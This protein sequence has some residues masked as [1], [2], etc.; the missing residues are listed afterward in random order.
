MQKKVA[1]LGSTGSIG[2]Q[3]LQVLEHLSDEFVPVSLAAF[4]NIDLLEEQIQKFSVRK[5]AVFDEKKALELAKRL[6][7]VEVLTGVE[8]LIEIATDSS[9][10]IVVS[11]MTGTKGILPTVE[12]IRAGKRIALANKEVLVTAG[13]Y[14]MDLARE[15]NVDIIPIDSEHSALFQCLENRDVAEVARLVITASGGPFLH[16]PVSELAH[17]SFDH[18]MCHPTWRMGVKNTIDS[19]TLMNK[20]L[21]VIEAHWLFGIPLDQ[22]D[23]VVHP[24]SVIHSFVEF[25]DH[26]MLAQ[27][28]EPSMIIPIQY[29]LTYPQRRAG[30][31]P[32]H[33]FT[34]AFSL[35]FYPPDEKKFSCLALAYE[36]QREGGTY[37]SFMNA[38]NEI[39]VSRFAKKEIS[40]L[41]I[42]Q[43]LETLLSRYRGVQKPSLEQILAAD[44]IARQEALTS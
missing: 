37:P 22:I 35:D 34:K 30:I 28:S 39:L 32:R 20:G 21:E 44:E 11:A 5:V 24:Q 23:V 3:A 12:A 38:A 10:D 26:S 42:S 19:S 43:K 2:K 40:W 15:K 8:G 33:D 18:A 36:A 6:P 1:I 17:V 41:E 4:Q 29:A 25:C 7:S 13:S 14:V 16:T 9:V 31:P 27:V